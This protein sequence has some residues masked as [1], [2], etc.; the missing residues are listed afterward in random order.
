MPSPPPP[1]ARR[2]AE[3]LFTE[4]VTAAAYGI[5]ARRRA[6]WREVAG[7]VERLRAA[8]AQ[9][10]LR[11]RPPRRPAARE[12]AGVLHSTG[13]RSTRSASA[14]CRSTPDMRSAEL[15]L[16]DRPQRDRPGR[17]AAASA[18]ADLR[19]AAAQ[20]GV[21]F[22]DDRARGAAVPRAHAARAARRRADRPRHRVRPA[23]HL[24]HHRPAQ[25]LPSSPTAT[26]CAPASGTPALGG[27][28]DGAARRRARHHAAAAQPHERDGV[29][30]DGDADPPAAASSQLDRFHPKHLVAERARERRHDRAL[31]RR[32]A[33]DAAGGAAERAPT[34]THERA[35]RLR[36]RRRPQ[37]TTRRS[38]RASASRCSRPG[39]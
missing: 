17:D 11:P 18:Q 15:E 36:R 29:L 10:R 28:G 38:R 12:P 33:G 5:D 23:L 27:A 16:P 1:R 19:A 20:A 8:Y 3:F 39:R 24:G 6:R 26:S 31:P 35:L 32:D 22:D 21:A 14:S 13:S 37:D 34:A 2:D 25:G 9:R 30:D 7:E 4:P